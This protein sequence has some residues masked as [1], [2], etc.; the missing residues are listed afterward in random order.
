MGSDLESDLKPTKAKK[1]GQG[2]NKTPNKVKPV[3]PVDPDKTPTNGNI[4][5]AKVAAATQPPPSTTEAP[6]AP[7]AVAP[8]PAKV[9]P[10]LMSPM[11][12][13]GQSGLVQQDHQSSP[14]PAVQPSVPLIP[15]PVL[16]L[17]GVP[18]HLPVPIPQITP[19]TEPQLLQA[20]QHLLRTD[21]TF[22]SKL[23]QA[24]V[25]SLNTQLN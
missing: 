18:I 14:G 25:E 24:Y 17:N 23:H 6:V 12:F 20:F 8:T 22:V 3:K 13:A 1:A 10:Q 19:L 2:A 7:A 21:R 11:V 16:P 4:S 9:A 15:P 5:Y